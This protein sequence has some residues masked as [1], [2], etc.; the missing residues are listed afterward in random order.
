MKLH[1]LRSAGLVVVKVKR[2]AGGV[3][4]REPNSSHSSH[5]R[6]K[7]VGGHEQAVVCEMKDF[8]CVWCES[9]YVKDW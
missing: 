1:A 6:L 8:R 9:E 7:E 5:N 4:T 3:V 2:S